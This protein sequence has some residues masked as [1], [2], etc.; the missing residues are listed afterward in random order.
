MNFE[1]NS[2]TTRDASTGLICF[3][4]TGSGKSSGP[5]RS[6]AMRFLELGYGGIVFCAKP[7]ECETWEDYAR[8][9]GREKDLIKLSEQTFCF[10]DYE[11]S[12]PQEAGGGQVENVVGIFLEVVRITKDKRNGGTSDEY[13]QNAIKQFLRNTI[14]LL[15]MAHEAVTLPNIKAVIDTT[16]RSNEAAEELQDY[17]KKFQNYCQGTEILKLRESGSNFIQISASFERYHQEHGNKFNQSVID[18]AKQFCSSLLLKSIFNGEDHGPDYELGYNYFL[19]EFPQLDERTRSNTISSFTVLADSMLRGEFLRCFGAK[20]SSLAIEELYRNGK[21]L[22]VDQDVKRHGLVGQMTAAIIKLCFE[23][24]IERREDISNPDALPVFLWGDECQFFALE[25][26]QKFQTTARSSRTLT[27]YATQNLDNLYDGYGKEKANSL[28][29]NLGTKIFCQN[30]DH[31][32]NKW[33]ADSIGQEVLR[34]RSQ[35]IGDS[36]SGGMKGDYNRSDNYS[37]GWSEQ[38]DYKVDIVQF[39]TLQ[40]GGP[41]GQCRVGYIYWQS[42]RVLKNGDVFVRGAINQ[43]CRRVCGARLERRCP[44]IPKVGNKDTGGAF[45]LYWYDWLIFAV[46]MFCSVL[47][48]TGVYLIYSEQDCFLMAIPEIGIISLATILIWSAGVALDTFWALLAVM[49]EILW[50]AIRKKQRYKY[51][52]INR[53]PLIV[54]SW[55]YLGFSLAL[56]IY[57]QNSIYEQ[58]SL[59]P[60]IAIWLAA[61]IAHRLFKSAGGRK[62]PID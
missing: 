49:L 62:I 31:T 11:L 37:E 30:G 22:I 8:E 3:G 48:A 20:E 38:K 25:Y 39:T 47:V 43:K 28:L 46:F 58:K 61:S 50:Y 1:G 13:W 14:S 53:V 16:L 17:L 27:V 36:K 18:C 52:I 4:M 56:A 23:K 9:K 51:K 7:D 59:F 57:L 26:D 40:T 15:V 44:A 45:R 29:G 55:L 42:G 32:T 10:L 21:I 35:N 24:M 19:V 2:W 12:R 6:I 34:R 41:R 5:L 60:A 54:I 33:A